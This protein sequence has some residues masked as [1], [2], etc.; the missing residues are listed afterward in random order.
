M[1]SETKTVE[2][3][4]CEYNAWI[5][6]GKPIN[7][8]VTHLNIVKQCIKG[9]L[10]LGALLPNLEYLDCTWNQITDIQVNS[11]N[12][13][14]LYCPYNQI[15]NIQKLESPNLQV[16]NCCY[17]Q[18][19]NIEKKFPNLQTLYC[20]GN[21]ITN[22]QKLELPNLQTLNC[23]DNQIREIKGLDWCQNVYKKFVTASIT[24]IPSKSET[25]IKTKPISKTR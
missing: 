4:I 25:D 9:P 24:H 18:I 17:N 7:K 2:W 21:Q 5:L 10:V 14:Y 1:S 3:G 19:I 23:F 11:P 13:N 15:T 6:L 22:I 12:L 16:L 8:E 20:V